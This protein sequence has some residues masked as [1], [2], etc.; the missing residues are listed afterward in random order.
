MQLTDQASPDPESRYLYALL[1]P[2]AQQG[3]SLDYMSCISDI[4]HSPHLKEWYK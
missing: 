2:A 3:R 1:L 4:N